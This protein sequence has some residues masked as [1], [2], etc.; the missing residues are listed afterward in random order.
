VIYLQRDPR[1]YFWNIAFFILLITLASMY[2]FQLEP[3][4]VSGRASIF[5]T[6]LLTSVGYKQLISTWLPRKPYLTFL[7]KYI[8]TSFLVQF[9]AIFESMIAVEYLCQEIDD[10]DGWVDGAYHGHYNQRAPP[11]HE[12]S[13]RLA[14]FEKLFVKIL[15]GLWLGWHV[16]FLLAPHVAFNLIMVDALLIKWFNKCVSLV[17]KHVRD[18]LLAMHAWKPVRVWL[19]WWSL[20]RKSWHEVQKMNFMLGPDQILEPTCDKPY[21]I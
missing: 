10:S 5:L 4:D 18:A 7:D 1:C 20:P 6:L 14:A 11:S 3:Q 13:E 9:A 12:C 17:P 16:L 8:I 19:R 15:Y 2:A 21:A